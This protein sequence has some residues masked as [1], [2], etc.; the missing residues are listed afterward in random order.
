[1]LLN[2]SGKLPDIPNLPT[3]G[4]RGFRKPVFADMESVKWLAVWEGSRTDS[5][6]FRKVAGLAT[7][8]D[9]Y[10]WH[11]SAD[12]RE[13]LALRGSRRSIVALVRHL[14]ASAIEDERLLVGAVQEGDVA[15]IHLLERLGGEITRFFMEYAA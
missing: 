2:D 12:V 6:G 9:I 15:L 5:D 1:M 11:R 10:D 3:A 13:I 14:V 7:Y 4:V 8:R